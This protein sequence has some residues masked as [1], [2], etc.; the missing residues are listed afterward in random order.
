MLFWGTISVFSIDFSAVNN[1][2]ADSN[3]VE[4]KLCIQLASNSSQPIER[5]QWWLKFKFFSN[6]NI[7]SIV[8]LGMVLLQNWVDLSTKQVDNCLKYIQKPVYNQIFN[9][10]FTNGCLYRSKSNFSCNN[11][12][13][14]NHINKTNIKPTSK[15]QFES[16]CCCFPPTWELAVENV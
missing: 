14:L 1:R 4:F 2:L 5:K 6:L 11:I 9:Q 3:N 13:C 8:Q 16:I 12:S 15:G 7:V 10:T